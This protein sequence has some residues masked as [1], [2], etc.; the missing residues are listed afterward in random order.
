MIA[1]F[2]QIAPDLLTRLI[3]DPS[4]APGLF[5][6]DEAANGGPAGEIGLDAEHVAQDSAISPQPNRPPLGSHPACS[7]QQGMGA[8]LSL[9]KAWHGVHYL[10][11]GEPDAGRTILSQAILGGTE[12]GDD[13]GYGRARYFAQAKV[14]LTAREMAQAELELEIEMKARFDPVQMA[15]A[16]IYP[17]LWTPTDAA[18]L[19]EEFRRLKNF[20]VEAGAGQFAL[21]TC[22][23]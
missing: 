18:W 13:L 17:R 3:I 1:R 19:I 12:F 9:E 4:L 14:S 16:G 10:L 23:V 21:V 11:C 6:I 8:A 20:Y 22:I 2:V 5:Q 15:R 7:I